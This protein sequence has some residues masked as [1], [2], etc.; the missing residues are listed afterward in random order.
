[1]PVLRLVKSD[2]TILSTLLLRRTRNYREGRKDFRAEQVNLHNKV[3]GK[4]YRM[5]FC[6]IFYQNIIISRLFLKKIQTGI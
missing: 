4:R 2:Y 5:L 1:M 3:I 6:S